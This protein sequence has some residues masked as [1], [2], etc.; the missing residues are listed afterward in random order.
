MGNRFRFVAPGFPE[1]VPLFAILKFASRR[2]S[3][4][5]GRCEARAPG[6]VLYSAPWPGLARRTE[7]WPYFGMN[8][9]NEH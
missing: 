4:P 1:E 5:Q 8:S 3:H 7:A 6:S 2:L 9:G